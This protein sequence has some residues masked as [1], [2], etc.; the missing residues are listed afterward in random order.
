MK[1]S[2]CLIKVNFQMIFT[3]IMAIILLFLLVFGILLAT[4]GIKMYR[5]DTG[6]MLGV[7]T[8]FW[9]GLL[10]VL[11]VQIYFMIVVNRARK[12]LVAGTN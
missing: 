5:D 8:V 6:N 3:I 2:T 7:L 4:G 12:L 10:L 9:I 11:C 1:Q